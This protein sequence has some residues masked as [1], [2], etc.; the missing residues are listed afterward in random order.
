MTVLVA[1]IP[2]P[3]GEAALERGIVEARAHGTD[4]VVL[5][6]ARGE[7]LV[8]QRRLYDE[9]AAALTARLDGT[10]VP[11]TLRRELRQGQPPHEQVLQ[12]A[13]EVEADLIVLGLRRRS[14]TG[15]LLFGSNAQRI[16]LE[17]PCPV[18]AVKAASD[19]GWR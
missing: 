4:L 14:A 16:L 17:A 5:N 12:V 10:G 9:D 6:A 7:A 13:R 11:Y 18:V 3:V 2:S 1:Y 15:K 8:E 19:T